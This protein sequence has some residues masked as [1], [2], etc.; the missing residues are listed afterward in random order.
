MG[1]FVGVLAALAVDRWKD[2]RTRRREELEILRIVQGSVLL[3]LD[4]F[5]SLK[6]LLETK[7]QK[8]PTAPLEL[9][10]LDA[11]FPRLAAISS[12]L[13]LTGLVGAFRWGLR[14]IERTLDNLVNASLTPFGDLR[15]PTMKAAFQ[16]RNEELANIAVSAVDAVER[17][18][19]EQLLPR[20]AQVIGREAILQTPAGRQAD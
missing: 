17:L 1:V 15:D 2:R 3:N 6:T 7:G 5:Q 9:G 19:N 8:I 16:K 12:D 13:E 14:H 18:A 20:L 11:V 10:N 4:L